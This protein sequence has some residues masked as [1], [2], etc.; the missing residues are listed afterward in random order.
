MGTPGCWRRVPREFGGLGGLGSW[1]D[2]R[3]LVGPQGGV[4]HGPWGPGHRGSLPVGPRSGSEPAPSPFWARLRAAPWRQGGP[5][6]PR[7]PPNP[8]T[9]LVEPG[10]TASLTELGD[11]C[12]AVG[13][14]RPSAVGT[15]LDPVQ[16]SIFSHRFMSIAGGHSHRAGGVGLELGGVSGEICGAGG[17]RPRPQGPPGPSVPPQSRWAGSCSARPSPPTSRSA[18][19]SPAPFSG[20]TGGWCPTPPT[21]PCTWAPCRRPSSSR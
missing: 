10:C 15:Q 5:P 1:W 11:V 9:I 8:S 17:L 7:P 21:S 12:I 14:G 13:S 19:T 6:T 20:R 2:P 16:L 4:L 18:S 3:V